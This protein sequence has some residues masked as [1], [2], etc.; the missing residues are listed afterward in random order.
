MTTPGDIVHEVASSIAPAS[1][2]HADAARSQ[3]ARGLAHAMAPDLQHAQPHPLPVFG[4]PLRSGG[5]VAATSGDLWQSPM[6]HGNPRRG[7][8]ASGETDRGA[9][10]HLAATLAGAQHRAQ[11]LAKQ[12]V[13]VVVAGDHPDASNPE[14]G[15]HH[16]TVIAAHAIASGTAALAQV[17]RMSETALI[18]VNA[19]AAA[20][21]HFPNAAITLATAPHHLG[22]DGPAMSLEVAYRAL[23]AGIALAVSLSAQSTDLRNPASGL[24]LLAVGAIGTGSDLATDALLR[25]A[26]QHRATTASAATGATLAAVGGPQISVL[27]GIML[28]AASLRVPVILDSY[29]TGAA[30]LVAAAIAPAVTGYLIAGHRGSHPMLPILA[31]LGLAPVFDVGLG[32]GDGTGAAMVLPVAD[33][34]AALARASHLP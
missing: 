27:A 9:L 8:E 22:S 3:V 4:Q 21:D 24:A 15:E 30:A 12:R 14:A 17:A 1:V 19:G 28:G 31:H 18:L 13:L 23:E 2:A 26:S 25:Q 29:A 10:D 16:S 7:R 5:G 32:A 33:H 6:T 34:V 20:A 11:P